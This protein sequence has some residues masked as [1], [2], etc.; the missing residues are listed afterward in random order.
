MG[1]K[2]GRGQ[3]RKNYKCILFDLDNTVL[4]TDPVRIAALTACGVDPKE[5]SLADLRT[6][7]PLKIIK[8]RG[9]KLA[10][11]WQ[12]YRRN[13][14]LARCPVGMESVLQ[15]IREKGAL[16]GIVTSSPRHIAEEVL[17]A[18]GL[19]DYF[20]EI[21]G[22]RRGLRNKPHGDPIVEALRALG[23]KREDAIY[24]GDNE[25]DFKASQ[26]A[27]VDFGLALWGIMDS[28]SELFTWCELQLDKTENLL[29]LI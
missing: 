14:T 2:N 19:L 8:A 4:D 6:L 7:S 29:T 27:G 3:A 26:E 10:D 17:K 13:A 23:C 18:K 9:Y 12:A 15:G 20:V 24:I 16:T 11:Y 5:M 28:D 22:Y 21:V 25:R 1:C